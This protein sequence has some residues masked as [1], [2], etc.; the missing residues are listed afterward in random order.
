[1]MSATREE[2]SGRAEP[3]VVAELRHAAGAFAEDTGFSG[4]SLA[5]V[6]ACVSKP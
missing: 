3:S 4:M 1:M 6:R 5:D 2:C